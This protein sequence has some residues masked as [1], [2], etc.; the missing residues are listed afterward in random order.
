MNIQN[1]PFLIVV[2]FLLQPSE[3]AHENRDNQ[4]GRCHGGKRPFRKEGRKNNE[5][6]DIVVAHVRRAFYPISYPANRF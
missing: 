1:A 4:K 3:T 6:A 2:D 5:K